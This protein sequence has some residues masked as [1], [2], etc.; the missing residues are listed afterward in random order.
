MRGHSMAPAPVTAILFPDKRQ[1]IQTGISDKLSDV[2]A[3][4]YFLSP[5]LL[6]D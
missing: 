3:R 4:H 1:T 6:A 5:V 2:Y